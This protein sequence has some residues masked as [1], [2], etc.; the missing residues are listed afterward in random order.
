MK[1]EGDNINRFSRVTFFFGVSGDKLKMVRVKA[2]EYGHGTIFSFTMKGNCC[3]L[4]SFIMIAATM[5]QTVMIVVISHRQNAI[6][7]RIENTNQMYKR[8]ILGKAVEAKNLNSLKD[9]ADETKNN[10]NNED[11]ESTK[12]AVKKTAISRLQKKFL[13]EN[14]ETVEDKSE[15]M[16]YNLKSRKTSR[17]S[18]SLGQDEVDNK[19]VMT[20]K[21]SESISKGKGDDKGNGDHK[22]IGERGAEKNDKLTDYIRKKHDDSKKVT[23]T[24]I[25]PEQ[26]KDAHHTQKKKR[27]SALLWEL[28]IGKPGKH[29]KYI[30]KQA[31]QAKE[32][33]VKVSH[34]AFT[35]Q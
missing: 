19:K 34:T 28:L 5:F 16:E 17:K 2:L 11:S 20:T 13:L 1:Q 15:V 23:E 32:T 21:E 10:E 9:N 26:L 31:K 8:S 4:L 18:F 25:R 35:V 30:V 24:T 12:K 33:K 22:A 3:V 27:R 6:I 14:L 29:Q 7:T